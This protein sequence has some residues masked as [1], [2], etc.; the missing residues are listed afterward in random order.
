[1]TG[2]TSLSTAY[3]I[4]RSVASRRGLLEYLCACKSCRGSKVLKVDTVARHQ[5]LHGRDPYFQYP[6]LVRENDQMSE[7]VNFPKLESEIIIFSLTFYEKRNN[8]IMDAVLNNK[9]EYADVPFCI[10]LV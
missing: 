1:M 8:I 5:R 9:D 4:E 3:H 10:V 2:K 6:V 7:I